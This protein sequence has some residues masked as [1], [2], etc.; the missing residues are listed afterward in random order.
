VVLPALAA[1]LAAGL[2]QLWANSSAL[3]G[4]DALASTRWIQRAARVRAGVAR[5]DA[6][7]TYA[8]SLAGKPLL[9]LDVAQLP[10]VANDR[11]AG[12]DLPGPAPAS[13]LSLIAFTPVAYAPGAAVAGLLVDEW[14]ESVPAAQQ[15]TGVAFNYMDPSAR[16]PQAILVAVAPDDFPEWTVESVEG[17][18]LEA[19]DLATLRGVDPDALDALGHYLPALYFAYNTGAPQIETVSIDFNAVLG[20]AT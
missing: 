11:W 6:A 3:Q 8:E 12:M 19:L 20:A 9:H 2:P 18:V 1:S 17:S 7:L 14:I 10:A 5:M 4:G 16:A 15:I 13:T